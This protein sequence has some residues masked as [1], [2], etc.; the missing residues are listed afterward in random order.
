MTVDWRELEARGRVALQ[1]LEEAESLSPER[2]VEMHRERANALRDR[3]TLHVDIVDSQSRFL[4]IR[5]GRERWALPLDALREVTPRGTITPVPGGDASLVG[6]SS[7]RG[8]V[9]SVVDLTLL[10][11]AEGDDTVADEEATYVVYVRSRDHV[12]GLLVTDIE[13]IRRLDADRTQS[14]LEASLV[15]CVTDDGIQVLEIDTLFD[16][17]LDKSSS[18]TVKG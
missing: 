5:A 14:L 9:R 13:N 11:G 2:V 3:G 12:L 1:R 15:R 7:L 10:V 8:Y 6:V 17:V 18:V 4:I 16:E